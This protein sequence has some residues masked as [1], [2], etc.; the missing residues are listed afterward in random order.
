MRPSKRCW[1]AAAAAAALSAVLSTTPASAAM[2]PEHRAAGQAFAFT[3]HGAAQWLPVAEEDR[4]GYVRTAFKHWV[5]VDK[6]G[7]NTRKEVLIAEAVDAPDVGSGCTLTG[8]TWYSAYDD[9][10]LDSASA[11]DV[12][13][14][15]PLAEAWDSGASAWT[16]E[17]REQ[18]ANDLDDDRHLIAVSGASNRSKADKDVREWLPPYKP[19]DCQY[20]AD[21]VSVKARWGLTVDAAEQSAIADQAAACPDQRITGTRAR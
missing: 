1:S 4:T 17:E 6:N 9:R 8:G 15:V 10:T 19:Y 5:D 12:D 7:C 18:Y 3:L 11:L 14:L 21:W 16:P 13:H 20:L 2:Q